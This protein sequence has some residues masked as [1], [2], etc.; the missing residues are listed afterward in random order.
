MGQIGSGEF[1][2]ESVAL[3]FVPTA[4]ATV[5][6]DERQA[7]FLGIVTENHEKSSFSVGF[8]HE[9]GVVGSYLGRFRGGPKGFRWLREDVDL[10]HQQHGLPGAHVGVPGREEQ[11]PGARAEAA[12]GVTAQCFAPF[13]AVSRAI[14]HR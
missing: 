4:T 7:G 6:A 12:G 13:S 5:R 14:S 2:G 3:G 9:I 8:G 11:A 10:R 1:I